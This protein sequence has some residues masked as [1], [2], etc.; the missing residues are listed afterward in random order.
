MDEKY[1]PHGERLVAVERQIT[2]L[3]GNHNELKAAIKELKIEIS[4]ERELRIGYEGKYNGAKAVLLALGVAVGWIA[5]Q[6]RE[7]LELIGGGKVH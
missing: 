3:E 7:L 5:S 1:N 4:K 2:Y 6:W